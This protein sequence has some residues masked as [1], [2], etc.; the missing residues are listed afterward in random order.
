MRD[1]LTKATTFIFKP[2]VQLDQA[3]TALLSQALNGRSYEKAQSEKKNYHVVNSFSLLL[4]R[5]ELWKAM[6]KA[7]EPMRLPP[8]WMS[9]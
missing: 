1:I 6:P 2:V 5:L 9:A 7:S 8:S 4:A 3:N